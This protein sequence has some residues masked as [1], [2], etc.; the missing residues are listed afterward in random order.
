[1]TSA[2]EAAIH[3]PGP[4]GAAELLGREVA[5][6]G[7]PVL[8]SGPGGVDTRG[9]LEDAM[10]LNLHLRTASRVL[11]TVETFQAG[12]P[13]A[14][15]R[16]VRRLPWENY[17]TPATPFSVHGFV[18]HPTINDSRFANLKVKDAIA[19]RFT[20]RFGRR[21]D[22]GPGRSAFVVFLHWEQDRAAVYIDTSGDALFRRGYRQR[23]L[24]AP[25][26][27]SLA[28]A[29]VL[30]TGWDGRTPFVN[31]MCGS[32]T[33]AI[34]AA[35]IAAG[36]APG[37][38]RKNFGFMHVKGFDRR[39]WEAMKNEARRKS[40][41]DPACRIVATDIRKEAVAAARKNAAAAGIGDWIEFSVCDFQD[42]PMPAPPGAVVLN[43]P[44][45]RRLGEEKALVA[46]YPA[47][48]DFFKQRC[49]GY[50]G[51]VFTGNP[52]LAKRIG[53]RT[54]SRK[55]FFNGPIECRLLEYAIYEGSRG[56]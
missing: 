24:E 29:L 40:A 9:T 15:Y 30:S 48:G 23:P 42:T 3:V 45:G 51:F 19:D 50:R 27:E 35:L 14:L 52:A 17:L 39:R 55:V 46:L 10:R 25:L 18:R 16:R 11:W 13:D 7:Y 6:L 8:H 49:A 44:Y 33:L 22:S 4:R 56:K 12:D 28:A 5:A 54:G 20:D 38:L 26:Q 36:K 37:L 47:V 43:P 34:E 53:L 1:M 41:K 21:P 2:G 31:P 32:G